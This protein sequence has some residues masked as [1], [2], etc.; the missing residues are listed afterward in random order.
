MLAI[1]SRYPAVIPQHCKSN[2]H[3]EGTDY[4]KCIFKFDN[5]KEMKLS[6]K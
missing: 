4:F 6:E 2:R 5:E 3:V 1:K